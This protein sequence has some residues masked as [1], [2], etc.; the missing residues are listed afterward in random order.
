MV[1]MGTRALSL[2]M[3][4]RSQLP[5]QKCAEPSLTVYCTTQIMSFILEVDLL[6][7]TELWQ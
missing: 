3:E 7:S 5:H 6:K 2:L 1:F 4:I